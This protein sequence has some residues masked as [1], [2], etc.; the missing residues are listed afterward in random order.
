[1]NNIG[2]LLR[3]IEIDFSRLQAVE[4]WRYL[5]IRL[6]LFLHRN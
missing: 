2:D 5:I 6:E 4:D 1:M 3:I